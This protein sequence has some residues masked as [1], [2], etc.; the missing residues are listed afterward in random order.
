MHR[1]ISPNSKRAEYYAAMLH[2]SGEGLELQQNNIFD[3]KCIIFNIIF[4]VI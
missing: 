2:I 3:S 1:E 4:K